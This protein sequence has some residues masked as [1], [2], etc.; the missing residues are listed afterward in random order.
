M[1]HLF[2]QFLPSLFG[3]SDLD[4]VEKYC[5]AAWLKNKNNF[6]AAVVVEA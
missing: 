3:D 2:C 6:A 1:A 4:V 5:G